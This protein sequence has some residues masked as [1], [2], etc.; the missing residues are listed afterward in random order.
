MLEAQQK[1][2]QIYQDQ[3]NVLTKDLESQRYSNEEK[4]LIQHRAFDALKVLEADKAQVVDEL[5]ELKMRLDEVQN[6]NL[7]LHQVAQDA[8]SIQEEKLQLCSTLA[9]L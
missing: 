5:A 2:M 8:S 4:S 6:E 9:Q 3:I 7:N 1:D